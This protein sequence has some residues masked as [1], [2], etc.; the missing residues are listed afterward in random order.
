MK[1]IY[2]ITSFN[3]ALTGDQDEFIAGKDNT[4][5]FKGSFRSY[6]IPERQLND[7]IKIL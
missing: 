5:L 3:I 7:S 4:I 6:T 1:R 2:R